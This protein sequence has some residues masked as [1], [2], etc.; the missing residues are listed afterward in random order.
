M[1]P[2]RRRSNR[3]ERAGS[4]RCRHGRRP[5]RAA[6]HRASPAAPARAPPAHR[7]ACR[8]A[9][10]GGWRVAVVHRGQQEVLPN[11]IARH[12]QGQQDQGRRHAAA[13]LAGGAEEQQRRIGLQQVF[14][15][16]GKAVGLAAEVERLRQ[17]QCGQR[18][19]VGRGQLPQVLGPESG[20][21]KLLAPT[22]DL[23]P[24]SSRPC[25]AHTLPSSVH[26][27]A[28]GPRMTLMSNGRRQQPCPTRAST[29][30]SSLVNWPSTCV[31]GTPRVCKG[32][33][34]TA[35]A[36]VRTELSQAMPVLDRPQTEYD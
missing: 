30:S 8:R 7:R 18:S 36:L 6:L 16:L 13:V 31:H 28:Y 2:A 3:G 11:R 24:I 9:A 26:V 20:S 23:H 10:G 19:L 27:P 12:A 21:R 33:R 25:W 5:P 34:H 22:G 4:S 32:E 15:Q 1:P 29:N 35:Q 14:E 17:R